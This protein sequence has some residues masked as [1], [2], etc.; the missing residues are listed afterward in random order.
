MQS[1]FP[2]KLADR[3]GKKHP[4]DTPGRNTDDTTFQERHLRVPLSREM[5]RSVRLL[6]L[7]SNDHPIPYLSYTLCLPQITLLDKT[8]RVSTTQRRSESHFVYSPSDVVRSGIR[9]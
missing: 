1:A 5:R 4:L 6:S 9:D 8:L 3:S 2:K 7:Q